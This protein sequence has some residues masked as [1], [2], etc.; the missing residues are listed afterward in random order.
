[1]VTESGQPPSSLPAWHATARSCSLHATR[2]LP[3]WTKTHPFHF[4][5]TAYWWNVCATSSVTR[6]TGVA[7][8]DPSRVLY[9][10]CIHVLGG[11][12]SCLCKDTFFALAKIPSLL[13][14]LVM[15]FPAFSLSLPGHLTGLFTVLWARLRDVRVQ[16]PWSWRPRP[17]SLASKTTVFRPQDRDVFV[18]GA[19]S[20][21][22]G[23]ANR[24]F[25]RP[26]DVLVQLD[27]WL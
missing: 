12:I 9:I 21:W 4:P 20:V 18:E 19:W 2:H 14:S 13:S 27:N 17:L 5:N 3:F 16:T 22:H 24:A 25:M 7:L 15:I 26:D 23:I 11:T 6:W 10:R 1:M 8:A